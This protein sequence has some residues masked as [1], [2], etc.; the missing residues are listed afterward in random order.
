M[1]PGCRIMIRLLGVLHMR[2]EHG[3]DEK[4]LGIPVGEPHFEGVDDVGVLPQHQLAAIEHFV[5]TY[6]QLEG[7]T[8]VVT[9]W[10]G[11]K[12]ALTTLRRSQGL[13]PSPSA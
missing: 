1:F 3:P 12:A 8:S 5:A 9:S 4:L 13:A 7:R 10:R 11:R 2:D 6:K